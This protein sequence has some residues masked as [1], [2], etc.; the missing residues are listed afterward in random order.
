MDKLELK[1][2]KLHPDAVIP[3][4]A[5]ESDAGLDLYAVEDF[6]ILAG[7]RY[8]ART[9]ISIEL[10]RSY[11]AQIRPRSGIASK[12]G[13]TVLNTPG[14][15]DSGYRGEVIVILINH[16]NLA[17]EV[18]K[19]DKIAQMVINKHEIV[20]IIESEEL[21]ESERGSGGLGST[22]R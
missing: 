1:V 22:G 15:I 19:G 11:E 7:E 4:Y 14:T 12:Y 20:D 5:K 8:S 2:R 6:A 16:S 21:S 10:P 18:K 3:Q 13:I 9:G 17:Y